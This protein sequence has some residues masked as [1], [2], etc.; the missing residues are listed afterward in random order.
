[1]ATETYLWQFYDIEGPWKE[2]KASSPMEV[3]R[4]LAAECGLAQGTH[5]VYVSICNSM[6]HPNG[7]PVAVEKFAI[8]IPGVR[9]LGEHDIFAPETA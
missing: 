6:R 1:M 4:R 3:A 9:S 5:E 8:E 2:M 7:D